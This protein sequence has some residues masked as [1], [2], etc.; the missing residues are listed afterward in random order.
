MSQFTLILN[1]NFRMN[2]GIFREDLK[3]FMPKAD[4]SFEKVI[5]I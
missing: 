2:I 1:R 5:F 3:K 4:K